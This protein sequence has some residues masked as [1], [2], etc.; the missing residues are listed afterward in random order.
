MAKQYIAHF[1]FRIV[2]LYIILSVYLFN[3]R[4]KT[5]KFAEINLSIQ[6]VWSGAKSIAN[7]ARRC[8]LNTIMLLSGRARG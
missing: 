3:S 6:L 8:L 2:C 7:G 4:A 1:Y 5:K